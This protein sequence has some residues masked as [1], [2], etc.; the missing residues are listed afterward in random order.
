MP[1][2]KDGAPL[3]PTLLT[4]MD[5]V[6]PDRAAPE[7][8]SSVDTGTRYAP[9]SS[10]GEGGM[11]EVVLTRDQVIGRDV[12]M[13]SV[14]KALEVDAGARRRFL[15]EARVQGQLAHPS[16]VPVYDL[17][18]TPDGRLYFTMQRVRGR[19]LDEIGQHGETLSRHAV[20]T[21][22]S[23]IC[24]AVDFAHAHGVVHRDIKLPNLMIGDYGEVYVLDWGLAKLVDHDDI[25][26]SG[27]SRSGPDEGAATTV[28]ALLG[29]PGYMAPEQ[30]RGEDVDAR[31]D[32]YALG[33]CLFELLAG[34][35]LHEVHTVA[36]ALQS[37]LTG[38]DA[39]VTVRAP[40]RDVPVELEEICVRATRSDPAD[41]F[42]SAR[43]MHDA[44]ERFLEG[45]RDL[46]RRRT[47]SAEHA[48]AAEALALAAVA[49]GDH[50]ARADAMREVGRAL[51]LDP[52]NAEAMRAMVRLL[53]E[54]PKTPPPEVTTQILGAP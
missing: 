38:A 8:L 41:R 12:A 49:E 51:A 35:P 40:E 1:Q 23:R 18:T 39:R 24:L 33:A 44:I 2:R 16:I 47:R 10:L 7:L 28:G 22:M 34:V 37:A 25:G 31:T 29:T 17:G 15:R 43:A 48:R 54:P 46:E 9:I 6:S 27:T 52:R 26:P 5:R 53:T 3:A 20:L 50:K 36:A 45:D 11:G 14:R 4:P 19:C 32:I 21:A 13:K 30:V 42:Q